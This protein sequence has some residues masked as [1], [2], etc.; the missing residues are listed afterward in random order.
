MDAYANK[1]VA[2]LKLRLIASVQSAASGD[3]LKPADDLK[4]V[5]EIFSEV[6]KFVDLTDSKVIQTIVFFAAY[7]L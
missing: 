7:L 3:A 6:G 5:Q 4:D 1:L 2:L